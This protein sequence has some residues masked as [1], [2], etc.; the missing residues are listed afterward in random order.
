MKIIYIGDSLA[1]SHAII[2]RLWELISI[3]V[4]KKFRLKIASAASEDEAVALYNKYSKDSS[5]IGFLL[6]DSWKHA[7]ARQEGIA[8]ARPELLLVN[9][10]YHGN[11]GFVGDNTRP[12]AIQ[13]ALETRCNLY[14]QKT[15]LILSAKKAGLPLAQHFAQNL[16]KTTYF[17]DLS[18]DDSI[19]RTSGLSHLTSLPKIARHHYD[20]IINATPLGRFYF[21]KRVEAFTSPLDLEMLDSISHKETIVQE[22]NVLPA[23][24]LLLQMAYHLKL[25]VMTG[26]LVLVFEAL[27]AVKRF[28]DVT[29]DQNTIHMLTEEIKL[30]IAELEATILEQ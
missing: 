15:F 17:Y 8:G 12:I 28:F 16:D 13:Q 18:A 5:V 19:E 3:I 27:E 24:P 7:F 21:D 4:P 2:S 29:L 20:V 26:E 30:Y 9:M 1:Q 10:T 25:Q 22:T 11:E 6:A 14:K 23:T